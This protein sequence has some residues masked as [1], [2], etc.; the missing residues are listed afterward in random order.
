MTLSKEAL[1]TAAVALSAVIWG[2]WWIPLRWLSA[3]GLDGAWASLAVFASAAAVL[4]PFAWMRRARVRR[5]GWD[6]LLSGALFGVMLVLWNH[7][8]LIGEVVRVVLL[9]YLAPV[10]ATILAVGVLGERVGPWR[11]AS[12]VFGLAGALVVLG[13]GAGLPVPHSPGDWL[14]LAAG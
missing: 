9:F 10:W 6:F 8:V 5:A 3:H 12:V 14:G 7:A 1:P 2:L 13:L 11:I 4:A